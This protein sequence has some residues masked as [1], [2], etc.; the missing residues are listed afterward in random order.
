MFHPQKK[1]GKEVPQSEGLVQKPCG[2]RG[3][4]SACR[5]DNRLWFLERRGV[6]L[7]ECEGPKGGKENAG[8]LPDSEGHTYSA[9]T[10][11]RF[12][13]KYSQSPSVGRRASDIG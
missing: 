4:A 11:T 9:I 10:V 5:G 12:S 7:R 1:K 3:V 8:Y 2:S 6:A 13:G